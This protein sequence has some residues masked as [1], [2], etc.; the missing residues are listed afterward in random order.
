MVVGLPDGT[1][2]AEHVPE[3]HVW[4]ALEVMVTVESKAL[5][6]SLDPGKPQRIRTR[7]LSAFLAHS[8]AAG[9]S[10]NGW[11]KRISFH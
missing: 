4:P 5:R 7:G 9:L 6:K 1:A 3:A 10:G 2:T 8:S 11:R